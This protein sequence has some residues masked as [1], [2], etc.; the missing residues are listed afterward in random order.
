MLHLRIT[1]HMKLLEN[2][3]LFFIRNRKMQVKKYVRVVCISNVYSPAKNFRN[4]RFFR[5]GQWKNSWHI[6]A[7]FVVRSWI[8]FVCHGSFDNVLLAIHLRYVCLWGTIHSCLRYFCLLKITQ[9]VHLQHPFTRNSYFI[10]KIWVRGNLKL[11]K[12]YLLIV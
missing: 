4:Y 7:V 11:R 12:S 5:R 10:K 3:F 2:G 8:C 1:N 9:N 6:V